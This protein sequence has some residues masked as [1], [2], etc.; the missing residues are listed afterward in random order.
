MP[1]DVEPDGSEDEEE[2][3]AEDSAA[4]DAPDVGRLVVVPAED[5]VTPP[6]EEPTW[7]LVAPLAREE[8]PL[9][10]PVDEEEPEPPELVEPDDVP[11]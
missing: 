5:D 1:P 9:D 11:V 6:E 3:P 7:A 4:D 8:L 10:C 2:L